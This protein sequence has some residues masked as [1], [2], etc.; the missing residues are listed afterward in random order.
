MMSLTQS[1][2]QLPWPLIPNSAIISGPGYCNCTFCFIWEDHYS[3]CA[4]FNCHNKQLLD[5]T[6]FYKSLELLHTII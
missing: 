2:T 1:S 5:P 6:H 4:S 3:F